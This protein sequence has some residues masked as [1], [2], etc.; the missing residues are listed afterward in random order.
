M[1]VLVLCRM[2]N[3]GNAGGAFVVTKENAPPVP[4]PVN[5]VLVLDHPDGTATLTE[6]LAIAGDAK[7]ALTSGNSSIAADVLDLWVAHELNTVRMIYITAKNKK[8]DL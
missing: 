5:I 6:L 3:C 8:H 1:V 2:A 4:L 7:D